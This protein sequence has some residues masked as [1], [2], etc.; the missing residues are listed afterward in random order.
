MVLLR[1]FFFLGWVNR[2]VK[3]L[4]VKYNRPLYIHR[5]SLVAIIGIPVVAGILGGL[6][7]S[8]GLAL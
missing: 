3:C 7:H 1:M 4:F 5:L 6:S 2:P 8:P